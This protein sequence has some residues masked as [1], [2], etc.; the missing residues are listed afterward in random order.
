MFKGNKSV[1]PLE[2]VLVHLLSMEA[3]S[4]EKTR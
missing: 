4:L 2:L 1:R 3:F